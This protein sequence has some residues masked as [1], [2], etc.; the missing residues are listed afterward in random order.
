MV[1]CRALFEFSATAQI[2]SGWLS[3]NQAFSISLH[4]S[5]WESSIPFFCSGEPAAANPSSLMMARQ[6]QNS[7]RRHACLIIV[8]IFKSVS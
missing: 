8:R 6:I 4:M 5:S 2:R 1:H 3:P 7:K